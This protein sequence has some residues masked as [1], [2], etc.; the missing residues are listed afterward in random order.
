M[1]IPTTVLINYNRPNSTYW[2][3]F[4]PRPPRS[5]TKAHV[6]IFM[7]NA[8]QKYLNSRLC[9]PNRVTM[10]LEQTFWRENNN[11]ESSTTSVWYFPLGKASL[12][13]VIE[14]SLNSVTNYKTPTHTNWTCAAE[15]TTP[16]SFC[17]FRYKRE[18]A[19]KMDN[20]FFFFLH[21][22]WSPLAII[23]MPPITK[24][25][26]DF[27]LPEYNKHFYVIA[28]LNGMKHG[29]LFESQN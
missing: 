11:N 25:H 16:F 5:F 10:K 17:K 28:R 15:H 19:V 2:W 1:N 6:L 20:F 27:N 7:D 21:F 12:T 13:S 8:G 9:G 23:Y 14:D 18:N 29:W 26:L 22:S 4:L 3:S 24:L